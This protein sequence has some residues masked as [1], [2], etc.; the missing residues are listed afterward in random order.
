MLTNANCNPSPPPAASQASSLGELPF[1]PTCLAE[2]PTQRPHNILCHFTSTA[3]S[4]NH[5]AA[6]PSALQQKPRKCNTPEGRCTSHP[7]TTLNQRP[8]TSISAVASANNTHH[9]PI[10]LSPIFLSLPV[11]C[12]YSE[13][14]SAFAPLRLGVR[15]QPAS[16]QRQSMPHSSFIIQPSSFL[17]FGPKTP[18]DTPDQILY[19]YSHARGAKNG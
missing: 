15:H 19:T 13:A 4:A 3:L 5:F 8:S 1:I 16:S 6:T 12:V 2:P 17:Q 11:D 18:V 14:P 10:S 9:S 7:P